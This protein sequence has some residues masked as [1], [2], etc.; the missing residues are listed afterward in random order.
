VK[1]R[2]LGACELKEVAGGDAR[3]RLG[4]G[5]VAV[6]GLLLLMV[7]GVAVLVSPVITLLGDSAN[8]IAAGMHGMMAF[9]SW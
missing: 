2:S 5:W 3:E 4:S 9:S 1:P 6:G 8:A 7:L